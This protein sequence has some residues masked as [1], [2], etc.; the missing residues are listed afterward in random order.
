M[1][2]LIL[3][4]CFF[5]LIWPSTLAIPLN[6]TKTNYISDIL[7]FSRVQRSVARRIEDRLR[8]HRF[9][10]GLIIG[11]IVNAYAESRLNTNA[12]GPGNSRGIFQM[13]PSGLGHS[14]SIHEMHDVE[15]SSDRVAVAI[16]KNS[17]M[18]RAE[19]I[20]ADF[21]TFTSIFCLEI[22]R[23]ANKSLKAL[24]RVALLRSLT[25]KRRQYL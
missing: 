17:R 25:K 16:K 14:M 20:G 1:N 4:A 12:V 23:P 10:D 22:E 8:K 6:I 24:H 11:A 3:V 21:E 19:S 7:H 5:L 9:S 15:A 18:M 13:T 2:K